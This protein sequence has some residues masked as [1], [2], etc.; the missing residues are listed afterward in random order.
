MLL[1]L[2]LAV[3]LVEKASA[4]DGRP[5]LNLFEGAASE[6]TF[7]VP[8]GVGVFELTLATNPDLTN[9]VLDPDGVLDRIEVALNGASADPDIEEIEVSLP[10]V[11]TTLLAP[12]EYSYRLEAGL[13]S[14]RNF[15]ALLATL[16]Y[17]SNL[18]TTALSDPPRNVS[19]TAYDEVGAGAPA[20]AHIDL[21]GAN[22]QSP[23][24]SEDSYAVSIAEESPFGTTVTN[25]ISAIDP[26]GLTVV[27]SFST[28]SDV[29]QIDSTSGIVTV[30]NSSAID[31]EVVLEF[32][33]TV[34]ATD[35]DPIT[36]LSSE[37]TLVVT[38]T[39]TNDNPP[40]FIESTYS[41][42]VLEEFLNAPV[43]T[44]EATDPD[45]VGDLTYDFVDFTVTAF[46]LIN[47]ATGVIITR[48]E[49]DFETEESF[50]FGVRVTDGINTDEA[51]VLVSVIDIADFRPVVTPTEKEIVLD[52]DAGETDVFLTN[53]TGGPLNVDDDST[54][55][56]S[57]TATI[58]VF[59][60]DGDPQ[61]IIQVGTIP[62]VRRLNVATT[63]LRF[64]CSTTKEITFHA[65]RNL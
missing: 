6:E 41:F 55:L 16:T 47:P 12:Q 17:V 4:Q 22:L 49:L 62:H 37:V 57:G 33:L 7:F 56:V 13:A 3:L 50:L 20:I 38:L 28:P 64:S 45:T 36:Q 2:L 54:F 35:T 42:D 63:F 9:L 21:R 25:Q 48:S 46:F 26:D 18:N 40:Q 60:E 58:F 61:V 19:I 24:F 8:V 51:M 10:G 29:F 23:Q 65:I 11:I 53:G 31:Y 14:V 30:N 5:L 59:R 15:S 52:V 32:I 44:V 39:D 34:V 43:G 27:Y 1:G